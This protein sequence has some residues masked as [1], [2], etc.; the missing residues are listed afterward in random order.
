MS[1]YNNNC[2]NKK[3]TIIGGKFRGFKLSVINNIELRPTISLMRETLFNWLSIFIKNAKCLDCFSGSGALSFEA[4]SRGAYHVT[5]I[6]KNYKISK[7]LKK[8]LKKL[9]I[10]NNVKIINTD[11]LT[12]IKKSNNIFNIIFIDPPF[13]KNLIPKT[14]KILEKNIC[15]QKNTCIY[16]ESEKNNINF[17]IPYNWKLY[18]EKISK[19]VIYRLYII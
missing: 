4:I 19:R 14:I 16:I 5:L 17:K 8:N 11:I 18:K 2:Y 1:N 7:E 3:I 15:F 6:E 9:K 10:K 13:K 12:W